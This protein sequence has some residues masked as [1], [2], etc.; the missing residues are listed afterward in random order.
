MLNDIWGSLVSDVYTVGGSSAR[1]KMYHYDGKT[2]QPVK[3]HIVEGGPF[4]NSHEFWSIHG[5]SADN[6][7]VAGSKN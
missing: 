7:Y 3:L 1:G 5:F 2:W 4:P 6:I